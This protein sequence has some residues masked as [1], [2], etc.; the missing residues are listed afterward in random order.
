MREIDK[1]LLQLEEYIKTGT[2]SP[3]ETDKIELKD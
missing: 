1:I 3:V 2:Y